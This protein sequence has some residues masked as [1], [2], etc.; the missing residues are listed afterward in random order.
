MNRK[1]LL[2]ALSI[3]TVVLVYGI[4][5]LT[6]SQGFIMRTNGNVTTT[7]CGDGSSGP[8]PDC[9]GVS[10][11]YKVDGVKYG[12]TLEVTDE[13]VY[14]PNDPL[15]I[16][17]H[18]DDPSKSK[19]GE[20]EIQYLGSGLVMG[21]IVLYMFIIAIFMRGGKNNNSSNI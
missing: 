8:S 11:V 6:K 1:L 20:P 2:P 4:W 18:P 19:V 16:S 9:S 3:P 13:K 14:S 15:V 10:Y 7:S 12:G 17:Y 5:I 21:A